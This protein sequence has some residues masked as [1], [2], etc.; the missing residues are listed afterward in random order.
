[1]TNELKPCPFCGGRVEIIKNHLYGTVVGY[2]PY[3]Q[4][5]GCELKQYGSKQNAEKAWNRRATDGE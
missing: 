4:K 5:C 3:C 1:M 2:T